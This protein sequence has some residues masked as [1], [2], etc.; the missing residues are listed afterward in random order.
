MRPRNPS[1][2]ALILWLM[3][4]V[5][6]IGA[7]PTEGA[8][9]RAHELK[10]VVLSKPILPGRV[11]VLDLSPRI[12]TAIRVPRGVS[13]I[14]V[15]DPQLFKTEHSEREPE[16]VFVKPAT[17]EPVESNL[18]ITTIDGQSISL[19]LRS[20]GEKDSTD[21]GRVVEPAQ[22]VQFFMNYQVRSSFLISDDLTPSVVVPQTVSLP[23]NSETLKEIARP[24]SIGQPADLIE[25]LLDEQKRSK[26]LPCL[27]KTLC[28]GIGKIYEKERE[29]YVLFTLVNRSNDILEVLTPQVQL[30]ARNHKKGF[31]ARSEQ[32]PVKEYRLSRR[33]LSPKERADGVLEFQKPAFKESHEVYLLQLAAAN[34]VDCPVLIPIPLGKSVWLDGGQNP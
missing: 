18:L 25:T 23:S 8:D 12:V 6:L 31:S 13:S 24:N 15:G 2:F 30:A 20:R 32:L 3:L 22:A 17:F 4:V 19:L 16:M 21:P 11:T 27:G 28:G 7:S 5:F 9:S 10:P 26:L 29:I 33:R 34:A 14:V 1:L